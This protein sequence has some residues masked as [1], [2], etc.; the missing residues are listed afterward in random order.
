MEKLY[1]D[2]KETLVTEMQIAER[3]KELGKQITEDYNGEEVIV[4]GV[5][6]G[7]TIFMSDLIRQI[8]LPIQIDFMVASSY[9]SDTKTSGNV[10]IIKDINVDVHNKHVMIVE[11]I[12]DTGL[13]MKNLKEIFSV[14]QCKSFKI[15][16]LLDKKER[17]KVEI[18]ADYIGYKVPDEF[19]VGYGL[20][21]A[22]RYRNLPEIC[23]LKPE[24]YAK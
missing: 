4:I 16:T 12:I 9:G 17:R 11:D 10:K 20:D 15:C 5:L 13:T 6:K 7:C 19:V 8:D 18:E 22:G 3:V 1:K 14:R 21:Y 2:I 24:V 23:V